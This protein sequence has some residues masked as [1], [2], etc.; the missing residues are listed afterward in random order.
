MREFRHRFGR[1]P[2]PTDRI[3]FEAPNQSQVIEK[4]SLAMEAAKIDPAH[5]YAFKKT[6]LIV[7][8]EN[9][10]FL[11]GPDL[12]VWT[13]AVDEYRGDHAHGDHNAE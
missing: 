11:T 5:V 12:M 13:T 4:I 9:M 1:D 10:D 2:G 6:G 8:S 7:V 3:F